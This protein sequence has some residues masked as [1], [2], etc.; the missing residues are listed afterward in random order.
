MEIKEAESKFYRYLL[1]E[2]GL[3]PK[4]VQN[5]EEDFKKF[6]SYKLF[7]SRKDTSDLQV[8]DLTDFMLLQ[9]EEGLS[10]PTILRRLSVT[11]S[12][13]IFL[14]EEGMVSFTLPRIDTPKKSKRIPVVLTEEEVDALLD[15]PDMKKDSGIRDR[16]MLEIMYGSGLRVSELTSLKLKNINFVDGFLEIIGKGNKE[17][18]V[19]MSKFSQKYLQK[20]LNGPRKR[21]IK[22]ETNYV[23]LNRNGEP[24]SRIYFFKQIKRY[25]KQVG[26]EESIS[27][28]TL[29]HCFATHLLER[30]ADLRM[31]QEM[32][33]HS[34]ISTTEIY[35][36]VSARRIMSAYERF[37]KRK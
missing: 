26:I 24:I 18:N 21:Y 2:K 13:F 34:K 29:R 7:S 22:K 4:T 32:L 10:I 31:V 28:H 37:A 9:E 1:V 23:F 27:P 11:K 14:Q 25:A 5:Y 33:G 15:A 36:S 3:S 19:P 30:G 17:R 16:A 6:H 20:Y 12:F 8:S 35:T